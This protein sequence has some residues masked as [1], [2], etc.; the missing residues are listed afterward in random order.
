M[1]IDEGLRWM[2][3]LKARY[4]ELV[5]LRSDNSSSESRYFGDR[6]VKI[7]TPVYDI[8]HLD[9]MINQV[10]KETRALDE[11]IKSTNAKTDII[12]YNKNEESLGELR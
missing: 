10:A 3:T 9:Q 11:A 2:K 12:G 8:K 6:E 4:S 1:T 5:G 7:S